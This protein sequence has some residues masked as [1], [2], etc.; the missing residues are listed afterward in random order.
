MSNKLTDTRLQ[1]QARTNYLDWKR[2][3]KNPLHHIYIDIMLEKLDKGEKLS[4]DDT[5]VKYY[6]KA[7]K[8]LYFGIA[9]LKEGLT[10][11][12]SSIKTLIDNGRII[13]FK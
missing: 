12:T 13:R 4:W 11:N 8:Q 6:D 5:Y 2:K 7:T 1:S 3:T 10:A 9:A